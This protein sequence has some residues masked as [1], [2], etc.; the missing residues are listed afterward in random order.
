MLFALQP[1]HATICDKNEL[2]ITTYLIIRDDVETLI[3][4]LNA[5]AQ[6]H[7]AEYY[8]HIRNLDRRSE[9]A[10]LPAVDK[11][12]RLIYL[13]RTCFNG[14]FRVN[15]RGYFNVPIGRYVN[16]LICDSET[17]RAIH[18]Y[19]RN[20]DITIMSGDYRDALVNVPPGSLVYFDPPYHSPDK[21]SFTSYH[22]DGFDEAD[23]VQLAETFRTLSHNGVYC[24]LSNADTPL[25]HALYDGFHI[26]IVTATRA[27]N[28]RHTARGRVNEVLI[29]NW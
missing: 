23:Q 16:P 12:A 22:A 21:Q 14:L 17:L 26:D 25:M 18:T 2:L 24:L 6:Q 28:S 8:T 29:Y 4:R 7:S 15:S 5:H 27:I 20:T 9:Y 13:N 19:L 3:A 10:T 11:A 1:A